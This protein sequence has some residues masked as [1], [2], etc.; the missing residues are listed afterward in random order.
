M[1]EL[2]NTYSN[3]QAVILNF[4]ARPS[5]FVLKEYNNTINTHIMGEKTND[6]NFDR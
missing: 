4:F 3:I 5:T 6:I 2:L 1:N